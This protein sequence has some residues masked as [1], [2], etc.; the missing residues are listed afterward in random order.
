MAEDTEVVAAAAAMV[1]IEVIAATATDMAVVAT[2]EGKQSFSSFSLVVIAT[3]FF[4]AAPPNTQGP[5]LPS[6]PRPTTRQTTTP[7]Q[8]Y[9]C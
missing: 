4:W 1:V 7:Y 2:A 8:I 3:G 9:I 6:S 5:R